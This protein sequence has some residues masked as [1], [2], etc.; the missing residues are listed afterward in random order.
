[1]LGHKDA[2]FFNR[3]KLRKKIEDGTLRGG[4]GGADLN[5]FLLGD[6]AFALIPWMVKPYSRR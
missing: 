6:N 2:Q 5:C 4:G 3:S 1:M